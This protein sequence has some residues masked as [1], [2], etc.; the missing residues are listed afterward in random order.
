MREAGCSCCCC[1]LPETL[2]G[3]WSVITAC[4]HCTIT[5]PA[6]IFIG[7]GCNTLSASSLSIKLSSTHTAAFSQP[8]SPRRWIWCCVSHSPQQTMPIKVLLG[9]SCWYIGLHPH[10]S[11]W[12]S[13]SWK[14][15]ITPGPVRCISHPTGPI[16]FHIEPGKG[17]VLMFFFGAL[18]DPECPPV[19]VLSA[20]VHINILGL[21]KPKG[22][23]R[24]NKV[25]SMG[26]MG[27]L[28]EALALSS[29]CLT[30]S[31]CVSLP[32]ARA[33][34]CTR[35]DTGRRPETVDSGFDG[36]LL[37]VSCS[38]ER[39][40]GTTRT[41]VRLCV[42]FVLKGGERGERKSQGRSVFVCHSPPPALWCDPHPPLHST[43]PTQWV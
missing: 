40:G 34:V 35:P 42:P 30:D 12:V 38:H 11:S 28:P 2:A 41:K 24:C 16:S 33:I 14:I 20:P 18:L 43:S 1:C 5:T 22:P 9:A 8:P 21:Q 3:W 7:V 26:W 4:C 19:I 36:A 13:P 6:A 31:L 37:S 15:P 29:P 25:S 27:H 23:F 39:T 32:L 10:D 17:L